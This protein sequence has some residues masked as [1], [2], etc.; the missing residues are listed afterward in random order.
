MRPTPRRGRARP[1]HRPCIGQRARAEDSSAVR[2]E[3]FGPTVTIRTVADEEEAIRL[4]ND[5]DYAL[6]ASVFS[7]R[8]G[9]RIARQL[10]AGQVTVNA[11][12]AFAGMGAVTMGG[13]GL[14]GFGRVHGADG[15]RE[16]AVPRS[17]VTQRF[18]VPGFE[19]MTLKRAGHLLPVLRRVI[20]ARH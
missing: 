16:F 17:V 14:S 19:L 20:G 4:A 18:G 2:E 8:H 13:R 12:I 1:S 3:T 15:L 9:E 5:S 11:V 7:A 6:S 10:R